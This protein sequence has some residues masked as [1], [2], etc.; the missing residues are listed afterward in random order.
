M[1][2]PV[3]VIAQLYPSFSF[4]VP[5][6]TPLGS[7]VAIGTVAAVGSGGTGSAHAASAEDEDKDDDDEDDDTV[8][9]LDS[10][11]TEDDDDSSQGHAGGHGLGSLATLMFLT[12][13]KCCVCSTAGSTC[14]ASMNVPADCPIA[15]TIWSMFPIVR[16]AKPS[17]VFSSAVSP[18]VT[19]DLVGVL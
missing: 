9:E 4:S 15:A 2:L 18:S 17:D 8:D 1:T 3:T 12:Y 19:F 11:E 10:E 5:V 7:T 16:K 13:I 6:N 14:G